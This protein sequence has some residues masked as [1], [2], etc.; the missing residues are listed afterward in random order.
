MSQ[1][2]RGGTLLFSSFCSHQE[3]DII[4]TFVPLYAICLF[5]SD[6]FH[7]SLSLVFTVLTVMYLSMIIFC[8]CSL[9]LLGFLNTQFDVFSTN[10]EKNL[11]SVSSDILSVAF[12]P[13]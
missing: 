1:H 2:F 10:Y 11:A 6:S 8:L 7:D 3:S 13:S 5:F 4:C 12:S 9:W